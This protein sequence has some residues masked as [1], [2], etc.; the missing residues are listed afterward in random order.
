MHV[1]DISIADTEDDEDFALGPAIELGLL[2]ESA[3]KE[4]LNQALHAD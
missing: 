4:E 3:S 1:N 2:T